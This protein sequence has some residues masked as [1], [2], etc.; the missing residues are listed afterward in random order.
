MTSEAQ[1]STRHTLTGRDLGD[2][3]PEPKGPLSLLLPPII[4][5][6]GQPWR[7]RKNNYFDLIVFILLIIAGAD[8]HFFI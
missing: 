2:E 7:K 5:F 4:L 3:E 1:D 8:P 6:K